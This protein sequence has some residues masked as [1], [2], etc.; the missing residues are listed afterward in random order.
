MSAVRTVVIT[1]MILRNRAKVLVFAFHHSRS[2]RFEF[3]YNNSDTMNSRIV[4]EIHGSA[5]LRDRDLWI[6]LGTKCSRN[7]LK[8]E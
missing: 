3:T 2:R 7:A 8:I 1:L 5:A 4:R 6:N